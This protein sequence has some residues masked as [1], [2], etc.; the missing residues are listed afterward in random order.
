[1]AR[2]NSRFLQALPLAG[3]FGITGV[4]L[5]AFGAHGLETLLAERGMTKTWE[6]AV[7]YQL[8][9][10]VAILAVGAARPG[11]RAPVLCWALGIILFSGSLYLLALGGP[12]FLGPITPLGGL[13]LIAGWGFVLFTRER[14]GGA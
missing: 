9:H 8:V 12:G 4:G 6:T 2:T 1:M 14:P 3:F 5:G 13:L 7:L 10:T 11:N